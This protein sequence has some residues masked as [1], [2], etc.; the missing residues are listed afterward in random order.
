M[1][2][3]LRVFLLTNLPS[4]YRLPLFEKLAD[5]I[6]LTVGFCQSGDPERRWQ[7][8]LQSDRVRYLTLPDRVF[9]MAIVWNPTLHAWLAREPFDVY[10][11]GE[12]FTNFPSVVTTWRAASR[13]RAPFLI[14]CEAIDTHYASGHKISNLYRRWLYARATAF[15]AFSGRTR[16]YLERRGAPP[17][18]IA[19]GLQIIPQDQLPPPTRDKAALGLAGKTIVLYVGYFVAR[20]GASHLIRA[21]QSTPGENAMLA[22]VGSGPEEAELRRISH[23]DPRIRFVGHLDGADKSNWYAAAD[24][25][26]LPTL[27][28]PWGLVVNEA[29]AFGLPVI[30]TDAAGCVPDIVRDHDNGRVV[31]A[32]DVQALSRALGE[33][34]SDVALRRKMGE[35]SRRIIADYTTEAASDRFLQAILRTIDHSQHA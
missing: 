33:L 22:L 6:E 14:W 1:N 17:D 25:F 27:H 34:L 32:G 12:N 18:R 31:P 19:A 21:F 10:I 28:D 16:Q 9:P 35:R 15:I 5:Q 8:S 24:V 3:R 29:M 2:R 7:I 26:V 30:V 4:P 11:A 20:K 23:G 13:T